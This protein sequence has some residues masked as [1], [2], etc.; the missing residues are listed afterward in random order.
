[1]QYIMFTKH[2]EDRDVPAIIAALKS[3]GVQGADLCVRPDFAMLRLL[4]H[5][6][7]W[8]SLGLGV[9]CGGGLGLWGVSAVAC[10]YQAQQERLAVCYVQ[11]E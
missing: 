8:S 1:M 4:R 3:V 2:L 5:E 11:L 10:G 7:S 9:G 6:R